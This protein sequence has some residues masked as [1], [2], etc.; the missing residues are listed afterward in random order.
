MS[1]SELLEAGML[2]YLQGLGIGRGAGGSA[3]E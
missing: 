1:A 3:G 2:I